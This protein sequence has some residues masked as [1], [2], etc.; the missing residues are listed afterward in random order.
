MSAR[1][2]EGIRILEVAEH[3]F[4]PAASAI[5]AELGADVIKIEHA[6][7]GDALR[8][9]G[10]IGGV[11]FGY[12]VPVLVEHSNRG[13][14]SLGL[15]IS[16]PAGLDLLYRLVERADVF[17][18]NKLP[19]VC[20][21]LHIEVDDI[22]TR[23][24][25]IVYVRGS[26]YGPKGPEA[27]AGGYDFLGYWSRSGP[28]DA[29][30]EPDAAHPPWQPAP[31]YGDSIGAMAIAGGICAALLHRER[32]GET[33]VV[34]VSLL[35]TGM[36]AMGGA[37]ALSQLIGEPWRQFATQGMH[38]PSNPLAGMY[39]TSDGRFIAFSML[40]GFHYWPEMCRLLG[41][42]DLIAD[43][44]FASAE[45]LMENAGVAAGH[46]AEAIRA[47]PL[48]FWTTRFTGMKGQWSVVQ[49]TFEV[50]SDPQVQANGYL[51]QLVNDDGVPFKLV[52]APVQ[53]DGEPATAKRAPLF[54]EQ[55]D[56]ILLEDAGLSWD[57]IIDLKLKGIVA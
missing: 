42:E 22:R 51:Q 10:T 38:A 26:G 16:D 9:L 4:V 15:D 18:T 1:V 28:A 37:I 17:L 5:L 35:G 54:N 53:F 56:D 46:V 44:R 34:D 43:E 11:G 30:T 27:G 19:A 52:S 36:W 8:G 3:T 45:T 47:Q 14:R 6:E 41:R 20:E 39:R 48:S 55:G 57:E 40:Q 24:P 32:T 50:A 21:K 25:D 29:I 13:K 31:A 49:N 7:R 2:L 12:S 23:N 33:H